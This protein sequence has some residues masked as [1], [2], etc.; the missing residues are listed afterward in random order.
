MTPTA[1]HLV[2][3]DALA[4]LA[5]EEYLTA[6]AAQQQDSEVEPAERALPPL[7]EAA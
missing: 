5:V 6:Q 2:L 1:A 4:E 3:I 7:H